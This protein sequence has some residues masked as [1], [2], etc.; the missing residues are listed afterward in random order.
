MLNC[1]SCYQNTYQLSGN[2]MAPLSYQEMRLNVSAPV[3]M[4]VV[5]VFDDVVVHV[6]RDLNGKRV[7]ANGHFEFILT[8]GKKRICIVEAKKEDFDQGMVQNLL[9]C[10]IAA[11]L[12]ESSVVY[13]I[14]TNF[15]GW[16]FVKVRTIRLKVTKQMSLASLRMESQQK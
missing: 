15:F 14:V 16:I 5:S 10:E 8:R 6:E 9:G 3:I 1:S 12:D 7:N 4:C 11:D 13:G 2:A